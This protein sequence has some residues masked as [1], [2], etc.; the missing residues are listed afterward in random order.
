MAACHEMQQGRLLLADYGSGKMPLKA[1]ALRTNCHIDLDDKSSGRSQVSAV[2]PSQRV[3]MAS[4]R[5]GK[6]EG[7]ISC[8]QQN[9]TAKTR[10]AGYSE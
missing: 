2:Q 8:T 10:L 5:G 3:P 4:F 9:L 6:F 7:Y 1:C